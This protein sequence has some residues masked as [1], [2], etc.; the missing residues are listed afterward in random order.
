[1]K[2]VV[3]IAAGVCVGASVAQGAFLSFASDNDH[4]SYTFAGVGGSIAN[5][6]DPSDPQVLLVDDDNGGLPRLAF[7]VNFVSSFQL[8]YL[9]SSALPLP[10]KYIHAYSV[11][12]TFSFVD[13]FTGAT[14]LTS[15]VQGGVATAIG[16]GSNLVTPTTWDDTATLQFSDRYGVVTYTWNGPN[17]PGYGLL[18]G[19]SSAGDD[20]GA[21]TLTSLGRATGLGV[22]VNSQT[23]LPNGEW[24][25]EGSFSGRT[26]IVPA[27]GAIAMAGLGAVLVGRGR[28]R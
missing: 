10:G 3:L 15:Q 16:S 12:G 8:T 4:T 5:A 13:R 23:G 26:N 11:N 17:L 21:F 2:T 7:E 20:D 25:S 22:N 27:P 28:R 24:L 18:S 19:F 1:M 6:S 14:I 9:G